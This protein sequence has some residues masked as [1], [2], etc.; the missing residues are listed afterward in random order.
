MR[1]PFFFISLSLFGVNVCVLTR[2]MIASPAAFLQTSQVHV[3]WLRLTAQTCAYFS[4]L[5]LMF[6]FKFKRNLTPWMHHT[7]LNSRLWDNKIY[8]IFIFFQM[9]YSSAN[10]NIIDYIDKYLLRICWCIRNMMI[11]TSKL[12]NF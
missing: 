10:N 7:T 8:Y 11:W 6:A 3:P 4:L 5:W 12:I 2:D 9:S 1:W